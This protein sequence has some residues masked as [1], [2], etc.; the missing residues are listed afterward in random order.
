M[1]CPHAVLRPAIYSKSLLKN[2]PATFKHADAKISGKN[3][4]LAFTIQVSVEDC[5]GCGNCERICP[6][7]EKSLAMVDVLPL[8]A[9]EIENWEFFKTIPLTDR[10]LF[11]KFT[12]KGSQFRKPL[13]EFSGAC[14]G[15]GETPYIKLMTQLFGDRAII[16]NATGCTSIY[17]GNLPTTPYCQTS[18]GKGPAWSNSLFEDAAEFALGMRLTADKLNEYCML[19][20]E[21]IVLGDY[22]DTAKKAAQVII[23]SNNLQ[24]TDEAIQQQRE[25]VANL[26]K[27]L[28]GVDSEEAKEFDANGDYAVKKSVWALG[29]DGW[30]YD[31]GFGGLDHVIS[32]GKNVNMLIVDTEVYSN[33]GGQASKS[34][35]KAGVAQFAA[36]GKKS[37]KKDLGLM[38]ATYGSVYV[39]RIA[40]GANP[41]QAIKAFAEAEAFDGPSII[42][43]Y[44]HCIAHGI[45][46]R[47]GVQQQKNAVNSGHWILFRY[48]PALAETG[49]NPFI[50]DSKEPTI[51]LSEYYGQENRFSQLMRSNPESYNK[52]LEEAKKENRAKYN[53]YKALAA[54]QVN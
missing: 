27:A 38:A 2:A 20:C 33:T 16:G 12:L 44:S 26:R 43:A 32:T 19:L 8:K 22:S 40:L 15:C 3:D 53:M 9:S 14:S 48:N 46:M 49:Q 28:E 29:G 10:S 25:N 31:I 23:N 41:S 39:A 45:D 42:I 13:F 35:P 6:T 52:L 34:T 30:A 37:G 50:L 54:Q 21:K 24:T 18:D 5:T 11:D 17:S 36:G 1:I 51:D 47:N 4:D 7:K